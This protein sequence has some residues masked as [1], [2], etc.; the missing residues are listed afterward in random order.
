ML[1]SP[2]SS[3]HGT[4]SPQQTLELANLH[5]EDARKTKDPEI[6]L[7]LCNDAEAALSRIK[8]AAKKT[9]K[10][11]L[12]VEDQT[13]RHRVA[14][15][16]L[17]HGNLLEGLNHIEMAR[18]SYEK[19]EKLGLVL[20]TNQSP[21]DSSQLVN[22]KET[23]LHPATHHPPSPLSPI[24]SQVR[25]L[26][27]IPPTIFT[28]DVTL[29]V[30]KYPLPKAGA[31]L[32]STPQLTYCLSLL[33]TSP[34]PVKL[35]DEAERTWS[36]AK[37]GDEDEQKRLRAMATDLTKAFINDVLKSPATVAEV[38]CLA[39]ALD[40]EHFRRL[41]MT[42]IDGINQATLLELHLLAGLAQ[43]MQCASPDYLDADDLVKILAVLSTRLTDTHQQSKQ[44]VYRLT[45]VVS[46]VLDAMADCHVKDLKREELHEPLSGYLNALKSDSDPYLVYQAAYAFQALQYVP[47][48]ESP[49][50]AT[51]RRTRMVVKGIAGVVSAVKGFDVNGFIDGLAH[52]QDGLFEVYEVA[53]IGYEGAKA[54]V[55][56][57]QDFFDFLKE[58]LS[59]A[60]KRAWYP[61]LR[62]IDT[63][64]RNGQLAQVKKLIC[65]APCRRDPAFQWG[66]CQR[67]GEIAANSFWD[68]NTRWN[69]VDFLGELY[70]NDA[71]WGQQVI[72][73]QWILDILDQLA[74]QSGNISQSAEA[75]LRELGVDGDAKKQELYQACL[76]KPQSQYPFAVALPLLASPSLLDR[77]QN[78][79]DIEADLRRL[80]ERRLSESGDVVYVSPQ[81]K[82]SLQAPDDA[83]FPLMDKVR[84][85]LGSECKV[86]LLLGDSGAGKS[87]FNRA[88]ECDLWS[89]YKKKDGPIPLFINLPAIDK[90]EQDLIATY[91]RKAEFTELQIKELKGYRRLILICDGYDE[92]Q[93]THNLYMSNRLNQ[94]GEWN[95]QMV[96]S[97]RSESLGLDYRDRFQPSDRN[98]QAMPELFQEAVIAPF[99]QDQ[100]HEYIKKYV[101]MGTVWQ[102]A[103]YL[104]ALES[105]PS[106]QDLVKNPFMLTLTME[107][108]PRMVDPGQDLTSVR[109]TRVAL[110]DQFVEQW[111]ERGKRRLGDRDLSPQARMDFERLADDGFTQ[112]GLYFLKDLACAIYKH[113]AGY[114][115]VT[116]SR[117]QDQGTWKQEFFSRKDENQLLLE[118]CP[119]TRS[120][121]QYRF[122]HKSI[123]EY[124]LTRTV[125]EP[126][127]EEDAK[128]LVLMQALTRRGS[129][130]SV[131]SFENQ[132]IREEPVAPV[133]I[134]RAVLDSPLGWRHFAGEPSIIQFLAE[135]VQQEPTFKHQLLAVIE[136]SKV[137]EEVRKAAANAITILTRAGVGFNEM[138]LKGIRI[139]G[140]DLSGGQFDSAQLQGADL[141]N[142]NLRNTWLRRAN[143]SNARM[144]GVQFGEW[145]Y[146][147]ED[148]AVQSCAYSPD[149]R[150]C[151]MGLDDG[152]ISIYDT[153]TW[154]KTLTLHGHTNRVTC[155]THSPSGEQIASGSRDKTVRLW[156]AQNDAPGL[157]LSGHTEDITSVTYSPSGRQIVSGSNDHT[158][159]LW[160]AKTG[161]LSVILT[162]N[163][164]V[165]TSVIYSP[166]G[167]QIATG[168]DDGTVWLWDTQTGASGPVLR[169]H[170]ANVNS[171]T[172][173]PSGHQI[174]SGSLDYTVRLWDSYTGAAGLVLSGHTSSVTSVTYSPSGHQ[175]ASA[176]WDET[177]RLWD[178]Q[179][180]APGP[181]LRGHTEN[182]NSVTYSPSGHQIASGSDDNTVR[183]WDTHTGTSNPVLSGHTNSV[184]SVTYSPSGQQI[185]S[186]SSDKTVRLWDAQNGAPGLVLTGHTDTVLNL[187][188][189]PSGQQIA[190]GS[191]DKTLRLW[192]SQ[193]GAPGLTLIGHTDDIT[194]ITYSPSGHQIASGSMDETVR[195]W[196]EQSGALGAELSGHTEMVLN[197]TYSPSGRQIASG[198]SDKTIRLWDARTGALGLILADHTEFVSSVAYLPGGRQIISGSGDETVR[199]W[200][201]DSGQC[202]A[203]VDE[204]HGEITGITWNVTLDGIFFATAAGNSIRAWKVV[205]EEDQFQVRLL[206]SS[207]HGGLSVSNTSIQNVQG[208]GRANIQLLRQR[209]AVGEPTPPLS[210]RE[211]SRKLTGMASVASKLRVSA[212]LGASFVS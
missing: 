177:V 125:F 171:V 8:K 15:A 143:L 105:I 46:H 180:G 151:A 117:R 115:V 97:C 173:S 96:I 34:L 31:R 39:P 21:S 44:H 51:L 208:L 89:T 108:L 159:R 135:R 199:L 11:P 36:R 28:Q 123:L 194:C 134:E 132:D 148:S 211:A 45:L 182:I 116:Y 32:E 176:S 91:F 85:F 101:S 142:V 27:H 47:D 175:I 35:L 106:L 166:N 172:Y 124:C 72:V 84:D 163:T 50:Q 94:P 212:G 170:T 119:L 42:F 147:Q 14:T 52:L 130:H 1:H 17:E 122:I 195:L 133:P 184:W 107:V 59:F 2:F 174:A 71:E 155:V 196:D 206:W 49:L 129:V 26:A 9:L 156:D 18:V 186:G 127:N 192:D 153:T 164:N 140:A 157:I 4:L 81:A 98:L 209:G 62:G 178:S 131:E 150:T 121:N 145:P 154:A 10:T 126:Q 76:E 161:A 183:L 83:L 136:L 64:I 193:T 37:A 68:A 189:S 160:D 103:D 110:Y 168:Y 6:A 53:K 70:K 197:V 169:G 19:A 22:S 75:L 7:V 138:D 137:D 128:R 111:L 40:Q 56:S 23:N 90:P 16:Y 33:P 69:A 114:P 118:A 65:E 93:Q 60:K 185:A 80:K 92:S 167:R 88:L 24:G 102:V 99:S 203:V 20:R 3:S 141:R 179:T 144:S 149:G 38:L 201:V 104:K 12:S 74:S 86:M 198:S 73:K 146:L 204:S 202:L 190:T 61:A 77:V 210:L 48:D 78:K 67:L 158:V 41:L 187:I 109:V 207:A 112:N 66:V 43:L 120:G 25:D 205:E 82:P 5:L 63:L 165:V 54:L 30:A 113:Q 152:T 79:P 55:E 139:P 191:A 100:V 58:G 13:L 57:G 29:P 188:Y 87:T 181:I 162:G 200:D 95:A